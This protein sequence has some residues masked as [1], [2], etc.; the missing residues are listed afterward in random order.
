MN[1]MSK[2][3]PKFQRLSRIESLGY[4]LSLPIHAL[5]LI[6]RNK[7]LFFL[8]LLPVVITAAVS[9]GVILLLYGFFSDWLL[10]RF[11]QWGWNPGGWGATL[12]L[13]GGKVALV[14]ASVFTFSIFASAIAAPFNDWIAE[15]TEALAVPPLSPV[16]SMP[17]FARLRLVRIDLIK[18][19]AAAGVSVLALLVSWIPLLNFFSLVMTFFLVAFGMISYPQTRRGLGMVDGL[20][21]LLRRKWASL[22]FGAVLTMLLSIPV[23]SI[24]A[25]PLGVV[26]G[27]LLFARAQENGELPELR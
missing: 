26:G 17:I 7:V 13:W 25:L 8:S 9:Y 15:K 3:E 14:L 12:A 1:S 6:L 18:T 24:L 5:R 21:F 4:G 27:T 23:I 22:G 20:R 10:G 2:L 11:V 19:L 16:P